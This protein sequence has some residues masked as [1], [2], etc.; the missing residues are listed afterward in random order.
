M[1]L[2]AIIM[3]GGEGSRLRPLTCDTPKPMVPVLGRPVLAYAL[4]LLHQHGFHEVGVTLQYL[5]E[6]IPRAFGA[7]SATACGC[8]IAAN[9]SRWARRAACCGRPPARAGRKRRSPCSPGPR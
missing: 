2:S 9:A 8:T 3:A 5:P 1:S 4:M 7:G 6:R